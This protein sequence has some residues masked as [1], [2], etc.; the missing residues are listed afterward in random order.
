MTTMTAP[1]SIPTH[2]QALFWFRRD[3][4]LEDNAGLY[5]ALRSAP[6]VHTVFVFDRDI[7]DALPSKAD[8]R[9]EFILQSVRLLADALHAA[10]GTLTVLHGKAQDEIP[11]LAQRL[12]ADA[13][14][15]NDDY[16]PQA[17][18]RDDAVERSLAG[19]GI[20]LHRYKDSAVFDRDELLN[21]SGEGYVVYTPYRKAWFKRCDDFACAAYPVEMHLHRLARSASTP[22]L[23]TLESLGFAPTDL[24]ALGVPIGPAGAER[25]L[26]GFLERIADYEQE[27]NIPARPGTSGLSVHNRFGTISV[28]RLAREAIDARCNGAGVWLSELAWRDFFFQIIRRHPHA[29]SGAFRREYDAIAWPNDEAAFAAWCE[30]RTGYPIVDA[31]MRQLVQTG[32][33]HNRLRMVAASFLVKDLL[34]DWRWG[35]AFFA[36][37]LLDY[38]LSA[39]NG[40]WQWAASTGCDAQPYFRIFSPVSQSQKF[41]PDGTF[42]RRFV[43]ELAGLPAKA[44][45]APWLMRPADQQALH[46]TIGRDYPAPVV[47]HALQRV[48]ALELYRRAR[49]T[50]EE[51]LS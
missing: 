31:A 29:A 45:H 19:Q 28:R 23:P 8:R 50:R 48:A 15:A 41:D 12:G 16:E 47:D 26:Q 11:R 46:C 13:V 1:Y 40:N 18:A 33:M 17:V 34:V 24:H 20:A 14:F 25:L 35:E 7:L 10:G 32:F 5:Y 22:A 43:P 36:R 21:Q 37:W 4:R 2:R 30:G 49:Q 38:D 51:N 9:V 6:Q 3:L 42:I 39:N 44:I 27:R